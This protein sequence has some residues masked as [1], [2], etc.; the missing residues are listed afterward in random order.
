MPAPTPMPGFNGVPYGMLS[1]F[2]GIIK[3]FGD[4]IKFVTNSG[5]E[6]LYIF[7]LLAVIVVVSRLLRRWLP[8]L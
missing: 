5:N 3:W 8:G 4:L 7:A 2:L 1:V 6:I